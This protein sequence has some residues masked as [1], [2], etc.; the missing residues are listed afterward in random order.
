MAKNEKPSVEAMYARM[1]APQ[2]EGEPDGEIASNPPAEK[3]PEKPPAKVPKHTQEA[4]QEGSGDSKATETVESEPKPKSRA[5][6]PKDKAGDTAGGDAVQYFG[7]SA[8]NK[9]GKVH[10][11][12]WVAPEIVA[13]IDRRCTKEKFMGR[14][15]EKSGIV[16]AA[17]E[18]YLA[19][20][21]DELA[22][23]FP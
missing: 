15:G 12:Y 22:K 5:K 3:P 1:F 10:V 17:L 20:E 14:P 19:E 7:R 6:K 16:E 2:A 4:E 9:R 11:S 18:N 21:L 23:D 13:A 8:L